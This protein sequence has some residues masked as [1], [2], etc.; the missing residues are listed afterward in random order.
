MLYHFIY[1]FKIDLSSYLSQIFQINMIKDRIAEI[2]K[3]F[4]LYNV[5]GFIIPSNDEYMSEYTPDYAKRLEYIT[6]FTGSNGL[7]VI[8]ESICLFF[9]DSRYLEQSKLELDSAIFTVHD[10][11]E[12]YNFNWSAYFDTQ[13]AT[14]AYDPQLCTEKTIMPFKAL[15]LKALLVNLV[16]EIWENKPARPNSII[17][18]YDELIAGQSRQEK[19]ELCRKILAKHDAS[20][21]VVLALDSIC[22][23]L[24]IRASDISCNPLALSKLIITKEE[25]YFF[26]DP[27]RLNE[28]AKNELL[29]FEV[30]AEE[31]FGQVIQT[32]NGKF[33]IDSGDTSLFI[34]DLLNQY[35][36]D[37][38]KIEDPCKLLKAQKNTTELANIARYHV[39]D[40]VAVCEFLAYLDFADLTSLTEYDIGI[41]L[42]KFRQQQDG[43]IM[44]SFPAICGFRENGAIIHYH[45]KKNSAKFINGNGLL[46]IDSGGQY[47]GATTDIT[48]TIAIGVPSYE[49]KLRYT[50]VLKGH[51]AL[52]DV[53][54]RDG[55][56][57]ANLDVLARKYLWQD[58]VDYGHGTGH[59][60]GMCLSVHEGPQ[61][62][63]LRNNVP[64]SVGMVLSNEPGYYK[65][66]EYGIRIENLMYVSEYVCESSSD[67]FKLL[68]FNN[69]TLVPYAKELIIFEML[70]QAE[71]RYLQNYYETI[72]QKIMPLLQNEAQKWLAEQLNYSCN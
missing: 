48:R 27:N 69:L 39:N 13:N 37:F 4:K 44:D 25:V 7:A 70:T 21:L 24:N 36:K 23:A 71:M 61:S 8:S 1:Q 5:G 17:Y 32:I 58:G 43:Y 12:L 59:G 30:L 62:I 68:Q 28:E 38:Q 51:I 18:P 11:K 26:V 66:G 54:F 63:N 47:I 6:G 16:D 19:I 35:G 42:Q 10:I 57:G 15:N 55:V 46:L 52:V 53:K 33:L 34:I 45:A 67:S 20:A 22:W 65:T 64:L 31:N 14:L 40:A 2:R 49:Q 41:I 56:S 72:R 3:L 9:T 60:V 29:E 50:Q